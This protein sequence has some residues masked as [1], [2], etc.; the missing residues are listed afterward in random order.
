VRR[1]RRPVS[2]P[3]GKAAGREQK[4]RLT[5]H[6]VLEVGERAHPLCI[7]GDPFPPWPSS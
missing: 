4:R 3:K 6:T 7:E 2:R 5:R 1:Y